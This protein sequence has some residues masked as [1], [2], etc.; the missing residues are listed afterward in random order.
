MESLVTFFILLAFYA[1]FK[2]LE[3]PYWINVFFMAVAF[4]ILTKGVLSIIPILIFVAM[5]FFHKSFRLLIFNWNFALG[6]LLLVLIST[7]WFL[8]EYQAY[9]E[10]YLSEFIGRQTIERVATSLEGHRGNYFYYLDIISFRYFS[11]WAFLF[12]PAL[13]FILWKYFWHRTQSLFFLNI[14]LWGGFLFFSVVVQTKLPWYIYF[15]YF[16]GAVAC[17]LLLSELPKRFLILKKVILAT[18][19]IYILLSPAIQPIKFKGYKPLR[20]SFDTH[21]S[22]NDVLHTFNNVSP[23]LYFY[24]N[25]QINNMN[26]TSIFKTEISSKS[27]FFIVRKNDF[28]ALTNNAALEVINQSADFVFFKTN[29]IVP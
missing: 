18:S 21:L 15:L 25:C 16:P 5:S 24:A 6:M 26:D 2:A 4:G 7:P 29:P 1:M 20:S 10:S 14:L 23:S 11:V 12:L 3:K 17:V 13:F 8:L 27:G 28:Y 9:G 19:L 22:K